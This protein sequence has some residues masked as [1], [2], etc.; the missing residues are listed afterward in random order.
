MIIEFKGQKCKV[1][2]IKYNNGNTG[3]KI[4][5]M[6]DKLIESPTV[7]IGYIMNKEYVTIKNRDKKDI[8]GNELEK[9]GILSKKLDTINLEHS[10]AISLY[11]LVESLRDLI[12]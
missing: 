12:D 7:D 3:F 10:G 11:M 9:A 8:L 6:E 4:Y 5:D 2:F 1:V